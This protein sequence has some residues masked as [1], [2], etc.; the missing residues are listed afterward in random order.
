MRYSTARVRPCQSDPGVLEEAVVLAREKC[1]DE[2]LRHLV[3]AQGRA[4]LL[5][6]LGE[7]LA[8]A[9]VDPQRDLQVYVAEDFPGEGSFGARYQ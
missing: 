5:A 2:L 3:E 7:Q 4:A 8:I 9:G 6:E 1:L